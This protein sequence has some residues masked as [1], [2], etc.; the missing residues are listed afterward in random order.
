MVTPSLITSK[1]ISTLFPFVYFVVEFVCLIKLLVFVFSCAQKGSPTD[2]AD[3]A[4]VWN[5]GT[6]S[7][8]NFQ[9]MSFVFA[10]D[11][12]APSEITIECQVCVCDDDP[13]GSC[14][15]V[16]TILPCV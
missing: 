14:I 9:L 4:Y 15:P 6:G 13:V 8:S 7:S 2:P 1:C 11:R 5:Q 16:I 10:N 3:V 12:E